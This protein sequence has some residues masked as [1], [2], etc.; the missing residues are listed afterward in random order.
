MTDDGKKVLITGASEGIGKALAFEY[1]QKNCELVL[2]ARNGLR[3]KS[4]CE[5]IESEGG[6]AYFQ[7][8]DVTK[9][10]D[11]RSAVKF[12]VGKMR[13]VDIAI[14]NAGVGGIMTM[15]NFSSEKLKEMFEVNVFGAAHFLEFLIPILKYQ[16]SGKIVGIGSLADA[17]GLPGA[18]AYSASKAAL[19]NLLE[20]ARVEMKSYG[21]EVLTVRPGFVKTNL[22]KDAEFETPYL[23]EA[24]KAAKIIVEAVEKNKS[25]YSFPFPMA[26]GTT[27]MKNL[28]NKIYDWFAEKNLK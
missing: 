24:D 13:R 17:R 26:A 2:L 12:A 23:M 4:I 7:K 8:C 3:L 10:S 15:E 14:L 6:T 25:E 9:I 20:S 28:P 18:G 19:A 21:I 1:A 11:A 27:M 5:Q 22:I 16:G